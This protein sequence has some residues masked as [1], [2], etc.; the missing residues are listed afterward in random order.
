M[1]PCGARRL[2]QLPQ[3]DRAYV[4]RAAGARRRRARR[5]GP[6]RAMR[7]NSKRQ[8]AAVEP[9]APMISAHEAAGERGCAGIAT[10]R[11]DSFLDAGRRSAPPTGPVGL[12]GPCPTRNGPVSCPDAQPNAHDP[13]AGDAVPGLP[14]A[15]CIAGCGATVHT[16][17]SAAALGTS[18]S[19]L[20]VRASR[21]RDRLS[22]RIPKA[23]YYDRV[24]A[25]RGI[26]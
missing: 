16:I 17:E 18:R 22:R 15:R 9:G 13:V 2:A 26:R 1:D 3:Q 8:L 14:L 5:H 10:T 12:A 20:T 11:R 24:V 25:S 7:C 21:L 4:L 19:D 23:G 6:L